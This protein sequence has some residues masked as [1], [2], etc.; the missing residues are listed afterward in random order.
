MNFVMDSGSMKLNISRIVSSATMF[1]LVFSLTACSTQSMQVAGTKTHLLKFKE[2]NVL[3]VE[4]SE[5]LTGSAHDV[6]L[7]L[8]SGPNQGRN[9]TAGTTY[10]AASGRLCRKVVLIGQGAP[11][12]YIACKLEPAAWKLIRTAI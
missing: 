3:P 11:E 6:S 8:L 1:F 12:N 5:L 10:F 2:N 9:M 7:L 4:V